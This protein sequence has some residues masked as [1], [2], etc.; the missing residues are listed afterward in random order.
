MAPALMAEAARAALTPRLPDIDART[1]DAG[2][3]DDAMPAG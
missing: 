2:R 3:R 1:R